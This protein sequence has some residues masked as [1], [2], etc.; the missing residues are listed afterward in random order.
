MGGGKVRQRRDVEED[1]VWVRGGSGEKKGGKIISISYKFRSYFIQ[2]VI[3]K[4]SSL[5]LSFDPC[6]HLRFCYL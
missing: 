3:F 5:S 1:G 2:L 6:H 4:K